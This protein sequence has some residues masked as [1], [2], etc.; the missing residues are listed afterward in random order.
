MY[1]IIDIEAISLSKVRMWPRKGKFARIH[2]CTRKM[3]IVLHTGETKVIEARP[4]IRK[5]NLL[6]TEEKSF[7]YCKNRIHGLPY[8]PYN[9]SLRCHEVLKVVSEYLHEHAIDKIFFKG[10]VLE[11]DFCD[12]MGIEAINLEIF[13]VGKA[14]SHDP[15]K[16]VIFYRSIIKNYL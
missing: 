16:E 15:L 14:H 12:R 5:K 1:A 6:E 13:G 9:T 11:K 7:R 8:Y 2:N 3:A 4:C 10:G